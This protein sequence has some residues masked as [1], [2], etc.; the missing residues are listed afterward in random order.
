MISFT[1]V[2]SIREKINIGR[3]KHMKLIKAQGELYKNLLEQYLKSENQTYLDNAKR[4]STSFVNRNI[5]PEEIVRIH[6]QAIESLYDDDFKEY[7]LS[8]EFLL[9]S[10]IA[11]REAQEEY[12]E[13]KAESHEMRAEMEVAANM[14]KTLIETDLPEISGIDIGAISVPFKQLNGDYY[15]FVKGEDG[16][17]SIAIADVI[18]KGVPAA[19]SMSMIKYAL[20]S[21]HDETMSPSTVLRH[22][23]RVVERNVAS[24][25]FIT[26]FYGQFFPHSNTF[27]FSS[28]G[29]EPCYH[30]H[31]KEGKFTEINGQGL[32][33][34]V[35]KHT[36]YVQHEINLEDGD[37][38]VLLTDGVTE[39][40]RSNRFIELEEVLQVIEK[41]AHLSAQEQVNQVYLHFNHLDDFELKDDFTLLIIKKDV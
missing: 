17:L 21:F 39:C 7:K 19:L 16:S 24:N 6:M 12:Y 31:A 26:M 41:Y 29:H 8:L 40:L 33:L 32:V 22:L 38:I 36:H 18:G 3:L 23:N 25:M 2:R 11:Y 14:Q 27:R 10:L 20:D 9:E 15:H 5:Y 13:L 4:M 1:Y 37:Y 28:A 34:G 30:Y 35:L